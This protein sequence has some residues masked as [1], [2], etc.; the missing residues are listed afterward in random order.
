MHE[1]CWPQ[2][3][4]CRN[5]TIQNLHIEQKKLDRLRKKNVTSKAKQSG[6]ALFPDFLLTVPLSTK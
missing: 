1:T 4:D 2:K 5:D 3:K 6:I